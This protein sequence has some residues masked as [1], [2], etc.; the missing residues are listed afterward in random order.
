MVGTVELVV[1]SSLVLPPTMLAE[2][3]AAVALMACFVAYLV[4]AP[5]LAPGSSCGCLG[6]APGTAIS[7]RTVLRAGLLLVAAGAALTGST[8]WS[9]VVSGQ[10]VAAASWLGAELVAVVLL[11]PE[12]DERWL[13]TARRAISRV[14]PGR[15]LRRVGVPVWFTLEQLRESPAH[16]DVAA[17]LQTD[18]LERWDEPGWRV[19]CFGARHDGRPAT[20]AFAVPLLQYRPLDVRVAIVDDYTGSVLRRHGAD[21]VPTSPG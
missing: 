4:V 12:L 2:E 19:V 6:S 8:P 16:Q 21:V 10:P 15:V 1:G 18:V 11:S 5:R 7:W 3:L 17:M 9:A 13:P 14:L 20:A